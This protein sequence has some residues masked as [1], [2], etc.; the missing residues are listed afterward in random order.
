M[1]ARTMTLLALA[2]ALAASGAAMAQDSFGAAPAT[3][4][5]QPAYDSPQPR[6]GEP[7]FDRERC[8]GC[9][10]AGRPPTPYGPDPTEKPDTDPYKNPYQLDPPSPA[11]PTQAPMPQAPAQPAG[12]EAQ[13]FGVPAQAQLRPSSQL[14]AP[15]PTSIPGGRVVDTR[16]LAAWMQGGQGQK[17]LLFHVLGSPVHIPGALQATPAGQGGSFDDQV[18]AQ[19]G[20]YLKQTSGGDQSRPM[21][22]YCLS[23]H[24]WMSYNAALRAIHMGYRQVFW[25]RGGIEAWQQARLPVEGPSQ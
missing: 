15:T 22:F 7:D 20:S 13:D 11:P 9:D 19:F 2:C 3:P 5:E 1:S 12:N 24:C 6:Q 10:G 21:V 17:P 14:H 8:R 25:Y 4:S 16:T 18:Q 23:S